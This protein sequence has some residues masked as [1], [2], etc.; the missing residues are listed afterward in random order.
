MIALYNWPL[1]LITPKKYKTKNETLVDELLEMMTDGTLFYNKYSKSRY[2]IT[3]I[4]YDRNYDICFISLNRLNSIIV[5]DY[6]PLRQFKEEFKPI[7]RTTPNTN[8]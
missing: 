4:E 7:I 3:E 2:L 6:M 1:R 8:C 5:V